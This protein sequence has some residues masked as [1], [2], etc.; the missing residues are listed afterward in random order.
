M[1]YFELFIILIFKYLDICELLLLP[2]VLAQQGGKGLLQIMK[3]GKA[4]TLR[5]YCA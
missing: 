1:Y 2:F 4:V 3:K 5:L